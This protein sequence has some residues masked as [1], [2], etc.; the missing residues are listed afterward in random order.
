MTRDR[1]E[2]GEHWVSGVPEGTEIIHNP[3]RQERD[4]VGS[5]V[6]LRDVSD[7]ENQ[8]SGSPIMRFDID[9]EEED[10]SSLPGMLRPIERLLPGPETVQ[11]EFVLS[12]DLRTDRWV[13]NGKPFDA[14]RIDIKPRLGDTEIWT[15]VN[16]SSMVH[17]MH[18]HLV[19]FQTLT[20]SNGVVAPG[21]E[22]WKDTIRVDPASTV[23]VIMRFEGS[24]GR[25]MY[26]CHNLAHEDHSMMGQMLVQERGEMARGGPAFTG[27]YV[28]DAGAPS[29]PYRCDLSR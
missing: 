18:F 15:F 9:R 10:D 3:T 6:V 28:G 27:S 24:T 21:E 13:I 7:P 25:Y 16:Q 22:G 2:P 12:K 29:L 8:S 14:S 11:R 4:E 19:R 23:R 5:R 17:P 26:H 1:H 20:R